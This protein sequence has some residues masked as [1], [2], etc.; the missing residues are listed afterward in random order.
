M[1]HFLKTH[2]LTAQ[3]QPIRIGCFYRSTLIFDRRRKPKALPS[4]QRYAILIIPTEF[5]G[6]TDVYLVLLEKK[7]P[8]RD[9]KTV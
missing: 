5:N 3:L 9:V 1:Q 4:E 2:R 7:P 8:D 6:I